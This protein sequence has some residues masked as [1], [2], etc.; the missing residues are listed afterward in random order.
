MKT[1]TELMCNGLYFGPLIA[2]NTLL[3]MTQNQ[4]LNFLSWGV[5]GVMMFLLYFFTNRYKKTSGIEELTF[6]KAF[7]YV[8]M[9][10]IFG[11]LIA[12]AINIIYFKWINPDTLT[13]YYDL[14]MPAFDQ[15]PASQ[16]K[17]EVKRI[18]QMLLQPVQMSFIYLWVYILQAVFY[19][20]IFA[21]ITKGSVNK[22]QTPNDDDDII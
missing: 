17:A 9:T 12:T 16:D 20:L 15:L 19:G 22:S 10:Y 3:E 11:A 1:T 7:Y 4:G 21:L 8:T 2:L 14:L 18:I 6:G 13:N 5:W